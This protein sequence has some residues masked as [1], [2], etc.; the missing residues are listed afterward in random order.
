[1]PK[2]DAML[3]GGGNAKLYTGALTGRIFLRL[4]FA[5]VSVL[6]VVL[7]AAYYLGGAAAQ[8]SYD[9]RL[10]SEL[11]QKGRLLELLSP[12]QIRAQIREI[13][14]A[15][16]ARITL[17]APGGRVLI[18][19]DAEAASMENHADRP[20]IQAAMAGKEG[21]VQRTSR[22]LGIQMLYFAVPFHGGALRL[23]TP[24]SV[25]AEQVASIRAQVARSTALAILPAALLALLLAR[26]FS[27]RLA[28][29][30]AFASQLA[31]GNFSAPRPTSSK[32]ELGILSNQ[33]IETAEKF[34]RMLGELQRE[35]TELEKLERIRK[36]FIINV[37]H[38]LRTPLASIQGYTETLLDGAL[39]DPEHNARFL[40]II[41]QNAERLGRLTSD[42]LNLSR[43]ELK[44]QKFEPATYRVNHLL[45][46]NVDTM[47]PMA[48]RRNVALVLEPAP[49]DPEVLC[50]A[51]AIHQ[52]LSNLLDNALKYTPE[53]GQIFVGA[54]TSEGEGAGAMVEF[55]VRDT[56]IGIPK[57]EL[58]R[59]F[60][61]FYRV[62]K[63]R[64]R[65]LGGTGL[66]LAIV[67][68]LVRSQ[69]G[70]VGV[71]SEANRGSTFF[72]TLPATC[73]AS[74]E[75]ANIIQPELTSS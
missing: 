68:H 9:R 39:N 22:T 29:I 61:R 43:L 34:Q 66:G 58:P 75:D 56:G 7:I 70:E 46:E 3:K 36:D 57:E 13:A 50:D 53:G 6:A 10:R 28:E 31:A 17:I 67:K 18:D 32:D 4:V 23:A 64:S 48:D 25:V 65:A 45:R 55:Y 21:F 52:V 27:R 41:R 47:R 71:T 74:S 72:F 38:E 30:I 14:E 24:M 11:Q 40:T 16:N 19:S 54:Q 26:Y 2:H 62:D 35:Q 60:E 8:H 63:A 1:M 42:L 20:E 33:L 73:A 59:L 49:H 5:L 51:E 69:G 37:S 44:T 12:V 15:S